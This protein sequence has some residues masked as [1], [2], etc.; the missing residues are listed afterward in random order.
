MNNT[1]QEKATSVLFPD[2]ARKIKRMIGTYG[3]IN[4]SS[5]VKLEKNKT[6]RFEICVY[7]P[8]VKQAILDKFPDLNFS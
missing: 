4:Q 6:S 8:S 3:W 5:A 1:Y 2:E 7:H